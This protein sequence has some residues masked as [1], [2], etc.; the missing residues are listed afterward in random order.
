MADQKDQNTNW[1]PGSAPPPTGPMTKLLA[2]YVKD[3][4]FENPAA[5]TTLTRPPSIQIA[6]DIQARRASEIG[7]FEIVLKIRATGTQ[8]DGKPLFLLELAY[9]SI[10]LLQNVAEDNVEPILLVECPRLIF[11]FARRVVADVTRDGGWPP[12]LMEA[13]D[14]AALYR[15]KLEGVPPERPPMSQVKA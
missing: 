15:K 10:F 8:D 2:Q 11:P 12:L 3:L 7:N 5:G 6:A 4:S 1:T 9:G 14:F 13:I